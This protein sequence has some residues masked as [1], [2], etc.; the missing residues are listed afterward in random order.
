MRLTLNVLLSLVMQAKRLGKGKRGNGRILILLLQAAADTVYPELSRERSLLLAFTDDPV[1][2]H[3]YQKIDKQLGRFLPAGKPYP[4]EKIG[5]TEFE[6][7]LS[8]LTAYSNHLLRM[9]RACQEALDPEKTEALTYSLLE[10]LRADTEMT[11]VLYGTCYLPKRALF[12]TPAHPKKICLPALLLGLLYQTHRRVIAAPSVSLMAVPALLQF[13]IVYPDGSYRGRLDALRELLNPDA[14]VSAEQLL[15]DTAAKLHAGE[16]QA[17]AQTLYPI[18]LCQPDGNETELPASGD[19]FLYGAGGI[20]KSTL[21]LQMQVS[22]T[23]FRLPLF[24]YSPQVIPSF[25]PEQSS[26]VLLQ[27]M[28]KYC[29]QYSYQTYETCAAD[30]GAETVLRRLHALRS[31]LSRIP[32]DG[33]PAYTLMLDGYNEVPSGM[34]DSLTE[35]LTQIRTEWHNVRLIVTGRELPAA[36]V[37]RGFHA[38]RLG[39]I[40]EAYLNTHLPE[41]VG[42]ESRELLRIPL[43][44]NIYR[45]TAYEDKP[46]NRAMMI[47]SYVRRLIDKIPDNTARVQLRFLVLYAVPFAANQAVLKQTMMIERADLAEAICRAAEIYLNDA[48]IYQNLLY[49]QNITRKSLSADSDT[50]AML[51]LLVSQ[52]CLILTEPSDP[53]CL[54]FSHQYFRDY[55]AA[56]YIVNLLEALHAGYENLPEQRAELFG[57]YA[58]GHI[59]YPEEMQEIYRLIGELVGDDQNQADPG[60]RRTLLD[61]VLDWSRQGDTFRATENV[62]RTMA[63]VRGNV[64]CGVDF[65]DTDLPLYLPCNIRF[66]RNGEDPCDFRHCRVHLIGMIDGDICCTARTDAKL[67]LVLRDRFAVLLDTAEMQLLHTYDLSA[68]YALWDEIEAAAFSADGRCFA[69]GSGDRITVTDTESGEKIQ[70]EQQFELHE[71]ACMPIAELEPPIRSALYRSLPH[72]RGCD[73]T[74]AAFLSDQTA[75]ALREM[76]AVVD[77]EAL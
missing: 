63:A 65:S 15:S 58:L 17:S 24:R 54:C 69:V 52:I 68:G 49:P 31:L 51:A 16:L 46:L 56:R 71:S 64:I 1:K 50:D 70:T 59:W 55:F 21:L 32:P 53:K 22:G 23:C 6:H 4:Y 5:F 19:L 25:Q 39:G 9:Q 35:E 75:D 61:R 45:E 14:E 37:F 76:G 57:K 74:G 20:G 77:D 66:S 42:K 73:F 28:L 13:H 29:C 2:S 47:D 26:S 44:L 30:E 62:I 40:T 67:L 18:T 48:R 43:F 34:Q 38:I 41:A 7:A 8:D 60:F 33:Q 10:I 36:S 11:D 12:G 72:F 3:A 27:I